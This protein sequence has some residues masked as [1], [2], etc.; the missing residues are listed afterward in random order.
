MMKR[1]VWAL[2]S[3][4]PGSV[5]R[6][7]KIVPG[8]QRL[9]RLATGRPGG[10]VPES[11]TLR[12]VVYLPTWARWDVMRQRPQFLLEAFAGAGHPVYFVDPRERTSRT[13]GGVSIV[14]S[15]E[16]VPGEHVILYLH[17][18]PLRQLIDRFTDAVV[19]YDILDDLTIYDADEKGL[20]A[21]RTVAHH[22]PFLVDRANQVIVSNPVLD[23]RHRSERDDLILV[24]NGVDARL[25]S[26]P[27]PRPSDLP[28]S[29][30]PVI[31]YRGAVA[32]WFDF[33]LFLT[34][35]AAEPGWQFILVG[36]VDGRVAEEVERV[37][38]LAN[39]AFIGERSSDEMPGYAQAFDAEAVWFVVSDLTR[40][41]TPLK[42]FEALAAGTPVVSTPL[43]ACEVIPAV[44]TA[45]DPRAFHEALG[46]ALQDATDPKWRDVASATAH[47]ADW[48]RRL[49]PLLSRLDEANQ[50]MVP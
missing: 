30:A 24:E 46:L 1:A 4:L 10:P 40:G 22:H 29:G 16:D 14:P 5:R 26:K 49:D 11:G 25:F 37:S 34:V 31:G 23:E 13:V 2:G 9:R 39:V 15:L 19:V 43:P 41:V 3:R 21:E 6:F 28:D 42:V 45:G 35:A 20:P 12:P 36:P 27:A 8:S 7:V 38:A 32:Q 50:R 44:R 48:S 17:F 33:D 18:A 47:D